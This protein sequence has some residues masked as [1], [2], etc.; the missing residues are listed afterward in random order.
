MGRVIFRFILFV[1]AFSALTGG[2]V[3]SGSIIGSVI[4]PK[5]S[6]V[7]KAKVTA[8]NAATKAKSNANTASDGSYAIRNLTTGVYDVEI[9]AKGYKKALSQNVNVD[10][11]GRIRVDIQLEDTDAAET[12]QEAELLLATLERSYQDWGKDRHEENGIHACR[13]GH[14]VMDV[15]VFNDNLFCYHLSN[16][17]S[18]EESKVDESTERDGLRA[19]PA[20]WYIRGVRDNLTRHGTFK[21]TFAHEFELLCSKRSDVTLYGERN[22]DG[23][24]VDDWKAFSDL[25]QYPDHHGPEDYW[26]T[27]IMTGIMMG[28]NAD[29]ATGRCA[30]IQPIPRGQIDFYH[31]CGGCHGADG[32]YLIHETPVPGIPWLGASHKITSRPLGSP[33]VQAMSDEALQ[34]TFTGKHGGMRSR[35]KLSSGQIQDLLSFIRTLKE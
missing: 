14:A 11:G 15:D 18:A 6:P 32:K 12:R 17:A 9:E 34:K 16:D 26:P 19:C 2:Q 3:Q 5:G 25:L 28:K 30:T 4:D 7:T 27:T 22:F 13:P 23:P 8:M 33:E 31:L 35:I 21:I 10:T 29:R 24:C 20:G 1:T